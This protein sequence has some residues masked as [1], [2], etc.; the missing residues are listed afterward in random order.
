MK[1]NMKRINI[2]LA[3]VLCSVNLMAQE[4][5]LAI[6]K[7]KVAVDFGRNI[8]YDANE[9]TGAISVATSDK[10]SHK[11]SINA[12]NQLFGAL[13]GLQVLQNSGAAWEDGATLYVRGMGTLNSKNPLVLVDGFERS[14]KELSS[15]EIESV[16]VLKDA[17]ATSLYGIRGANGVILVKTKRGSMSAPQIN[18]SYEFNMAT[19]NRLPDF[20]DGYTYA[21]A[22]NEAMRNDGSLPR[23]SQTELDA[24]KNQTN[25]MFYPNVDWVDET[26]R[27]ASYGD[28]VNFSARGGGKFV[29]YYT[30]LNFL[31]NRGILQ[32]TGDNDGYSTQLK[33]SKLNIRTNLDITVSPTTSVQLNLLGNFSEH[34]RPGTTVGDIFIALYQVPSGAFPIKTENGIWGGTTTYGNNPVANISGKGYAR[35]QTRALFADMHL[36]QDLSMLLPGL[37]AGLKIALDNSAAYWDSNTKDYGYE[38]A[39]IDLATGEKTFNTLRNEGTLRFSKS[40]GSI[41]THFNFEAYAN[42]LKQWGKHNLNATFMYAMDKTKSKGRNTGRAFMDVMG[43][44]HYSYNHRYLLDFSLSG[45]ASSILDPDNRWG[46]FPAVGAGWILSK[47]DFMK[48]D[49]LNLLKLR[50]SYGISGRADFGVNLFQNIFGSGNSYLFKDTPQSIGGGMKLTQLGVDGFTYEKS[51]KLNVGIDFRAWN[52]LSLSLDAFYDHR[53]DILVGGGGAVSSIFGV[54]VP[55]INDGVVDNKGVEASLNWDDKIA[56]FTYHLGGQFSFVRNKIINQNE[57]YQPY[58]Y[59]KRTGKS[60]NQFFGYEVVGIYQSQKEIDD[61]EVKQ[62]LGYVRPGDLM[63]KDQNGDK[64]IDSYDQ[65]AL[66]YNSACPEIYYSF[67][68]GVEYKGVGIYALFQGTGNYSKLLDTRSIYRPIVGNNT[69]SSYY[70]ENRWSES[71]PGGTLPRLT[72]AGS[73]NNYN[74]NSLWVADASFLKLRTLELYYN[75]PAKLLKRT[76]FLGG[77][78]IYARA[79]DLFCL[80]GIDIRDPE[81]IGAEHPTMTQYAFGFN[82]SF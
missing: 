34:N 78:K 61:R 54:P 25:P 45:S 15:E 40:V 81:A 7:D 75:L 48:N 33:Y 26:L 29:R 76:K 53:T 68:L 58:D 18:F 27:G 8:T 30:M 10:L 36:K 82:L 19:P 23:Y 52:K 4:D 43:Q 38:S 63:F 21:S 77:A 64:R 5:T 72:Y 60:L 16:S 50:A 11:N 57:K 71:N 73:D 46:I 24:F 31:D 55:K 66:G 32:P 70:Y 2:I 9:V 41:T 65:I 37:T 14:I 6:E 17:V 12:S 22:L 59:L 39:A 1:F 42:Y 74:N 69:I 44:V 80:D 67:D 35:S 49:W 20:V 28:N 3:S 56:D 47:E 79:H 51:H 62:Y 13:S